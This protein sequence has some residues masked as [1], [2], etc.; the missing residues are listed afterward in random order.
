MDVQGGRLENRA[1]AAAAKAPWK[2][3][4]GREKATPLIIGGITAR[5]NIAIS[6]HSASPR[7]LLAR[8]TSRGGGGGGESY[9]QRA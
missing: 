4:A 8:I 2:T 1:L 7:A 6:E 5:Q 9:Q 3:S